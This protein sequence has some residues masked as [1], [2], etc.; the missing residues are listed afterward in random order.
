MGASASSVI[1]NAAEAGDTLPAASVAVVVIVFAPLARSPVSK[2]KLQLPA[3]SAVVVPT[4]VAPT[5]TVTVAFAS[6][7]PEMVAVVSLVSA[8][9]VSPELDATS[10][11]AA[12]GAAGTVASLATVSVTALAALPAS[13]V[14]V[15]V[16]VSV[17]SSSPDRSRLATC[18][19]APATVPVPVTLVPPPD[20]EI[21]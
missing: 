5:N 15:T 12:E 19:E 6:A 7:V 9:V 21:A 11:V 20:E 10:N 1:T 13:S 2:V 18:S 3:P 8:S 17:P 16:R 4:E 14:S